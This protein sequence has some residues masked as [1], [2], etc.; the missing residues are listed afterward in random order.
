[1]QRI[2]IIGANSS[3][4]EAAARVWAKRGDRLFLLGRSEERLGA[5]SADLSV[6]G[7]DLAGHASFDANA[8]DHHAEIL[9]KAVHRLGGLD[10]A[11]IAYGTLADQDRAKVD[12]AYALHEIHTNA[13][14]VVS[15][16]SILANALEAQGRGTLAVISSVAGERGRQSNYV[17]GSAKALVTAFTQGLRNRLYS[18]GV[19][20][21]TLKP[22]FVATAMTAHLPQGPLFASADTA[23]ACIVRAIDKKKNVAY[24][25]A[26][27]ALIMLVI[28]SIPESLFKKLKL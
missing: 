16:C 27:W 14:S 11:L 6:R 20:V 28:R 19:H 3:M 22:G 24:V 17:Y 26:F 7:G 8:L 13:V 15:L 10:V 25:P 1:M 9:E 12:V 21:V 2:L 5:L 18:K 4:A 23:G